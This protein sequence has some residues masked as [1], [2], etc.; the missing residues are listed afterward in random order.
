M[1]TYKSKEDFLNMSIA[2]KV[3]KSIHEEIRN[4]AIEGVTLK[5]LDLIAKKM[6]LIN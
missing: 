1:I 3:V 5:E 6:R 4:N 2:G